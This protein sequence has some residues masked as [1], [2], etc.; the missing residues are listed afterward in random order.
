MNKNIFDFEISS[1]P[2]FCILD[3]TVSMLETLDFETI[4]TSKD[5]MNI[6]D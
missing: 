4:F 1:K 2:N 5:V 6:Q 3:I